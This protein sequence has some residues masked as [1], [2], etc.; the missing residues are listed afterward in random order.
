[1]TNLTQRKLW[2][3]L[4][5][6]AAALG[7][8]ASA[9]AAVFVQCPGDTNGDA[10]WTGSETR[11]ANTSCM[12][13]TGGDGF[14]TMADGRQMYNFGF[15]DVTGTRPADVVLNLA[16]A[17]FVAP[18]IELQEG[19]KFYLTLTNVG[20]VARPDL[21]DAHSV[22]FHGFAN[23]API[24]DGVPE[25]SIT[26][27]MGSSLTYFYNLTEPGTYMYHCHFEAAEHI[28]MGMQGQLFVKPRQDGTPKVFGGRTYTRFVYNDGDGST[29]YD[30]AVALQLTAFDTA[31]HESDLNIQPIDFNS[32]KTVY[33][34]INGRGYPDTINPGALP[35][36]QF[37]PYTADTTYQSQKITSLVTLD[38]G[39]EGTRLLLRLSN[40]GVADYYTVTALGLPMKVV[41]AG[42]RQLR[43][44]SGKDLYYDTSSVTLGGGE[45]AEVM[46]DTASVSPGTYFLYTRNLNFLSNNQDDY[47]GLMTEIV[48]R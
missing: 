2:I 34:M 18:T 30:K 7:I 1:M 5:A 37:D 39:T 32:M 40:L 3:G 11:P 21:F 29:G 27:N 47:G 46:I 4:A 48:V 19:N 16:R 12:H 9:R 31:T 36:T 33:P 25:P 41:G 38:R 28:Q 44:P 35:P 22:H 23:Q 42:A 10:T 14:V 26:P 43:G 24:F 17:N 45:S 13:I 8:S 20:M 15:E 6:G